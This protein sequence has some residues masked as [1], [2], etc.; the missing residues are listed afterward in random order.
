MST[1]AAGFVPPISSPSNVIVPSVGVRRPEMVLSTVDF[2]APLAPS[3]ATFSP[4]FT[5][6]STP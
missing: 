3:R 6:M 5:S 4:T 1:S 2:P